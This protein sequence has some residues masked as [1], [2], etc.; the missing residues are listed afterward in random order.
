MWELDHSPLTM[1]V[2]LKIGNWLHLAHFIV[3]NPTP[4][5]CTS[6]PTRIEAKKH[7]CVWIKCLHFGASSCL[8]I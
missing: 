1:L 3:V 2:D 4:N 7:L 6:R 8:R 5:N